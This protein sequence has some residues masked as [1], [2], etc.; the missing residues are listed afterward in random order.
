MKP[1]GEAVDLSRILTD[2]CALPDEMIEC[3]A[4]LARRSSSPI[5]VSGEPRHSLQLHGH[6]V[7]ED[8]EDAFLELAQAVLACVEGSDELELER[9]ES[10]RRE[11]ERGETVRFE[12]FFH[13]IPVYR[14]GVSLF[15]AAGS[16]L[17]ETV[18]V[19]L[20]R[21][22]PAEAEWG[23]AG[24]A[25]ATLREQWG[26]NDVEAPW[27]LR[28]GRKMWY[29]TSLVHGSVEGD[30]WQPAWIF[31]SGTD[32]ENP[33]DVVVSG[34]GQTVVDTIVVGDGMSL[35]PVPRYH[36][37][38]ETGVPDFVTWGQTGLL[39]PEAGTGDPAR[40][41]RALFDRYPTLF[42]T[43]DSRNQ[44][45]LMETSVSTGVPRT[46]HVVFQQMYGS[47]PVYGCQLR[48][49]LSPTLAIRSVSGTYLR[50]PQVALDVSVPEAQ[51]MSNLSVGYAVGDD[52]EAVPRSEMTSKGLVVF[53]AVLAPGGGP[54][55]HLAWWIA[56]PHWHYFVSAESGRV[57]Y[58]I[59][60]EENARLT[61]DAN[62][63]VSGE[64]L[65][66]RDGI[67]VT[68][69]GAPDADS[70]PTDM[71]VGLFEGFLL[72]LFGWRSWDNH[73]SDDIAIIDYPDHGNAHW[74]S[75]DNRARFDRNFTTSEVIG[76]EFTHGIV[77]TTAGLNYVGESGALNESFADVIGKL[78]F[79]GAPPNWK[80]FNN[81]GTQIRDLQNPDV[82]KYSKLNNFPLDHF[83]VHS[84][85]GISSR[86]AVLTCDGD[87][88]AGRSGIGRE[89]TT[90]LWWDVMTLRLHPW[91]TFLDFSHAVRE[92]VRD[93]A[94]MGTAGVAAPASGAAAG[95]PL[96]VFDMPAISQVDWA[97][98]QVELTPSLQSGWFTIPGTFLEKMTFFPGAFVPADEVVTTAEV[99]AIRRRDADKTQFLFGR[100]IVPGTGRFV[101]QSGTV[102]V[103]ITSH[104]VGSQSK[105]ITADITNTSGLNTEVSGNVYTQPIAPPPPSP[106]PPVTQ[107]TSPY[108]PHWF[109]NPLFLGRKYGDIIFEM[110]SMAATCTILDVWVEILEKTANGVLVPMGQARI[111]DPAAILRGTGVVLVDAHPGTS[112]LEAKVRSWHDFGQIVRYRIVYEISGGCMPPPFMFRGVDPA[113][114]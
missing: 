66:V 22:E 12:V 19:V 55:N 4:K 84:N 91:A 65:D 44:L 21:E 11:G 5:V 26:L 64:V 27:L 1:A 32:V 77:Q 81:D 15:V 46:K 79:P 80:S 93:L 53:P 33:F 73:G 110:V 89:L 109:D 45:S 36:I 16:G 62:Q 90:R 28:R 114:F 8:G 75:E 23:D 58:R 7:V 43:G 70:V 86:C 60:A 37:R 50:D 71:T 85:S 108:I 13:G 92:T 41:A 101:D 17:I 99:L 48:V 95:G 105:Q 14:G 98:D 10:D 49:H 39:L 52:R 9:R 112:L 102:I 94:S 111:G 96:P 18:S 29:S 38:P 67:V 88:A 113:T 24:V 78:A 61:Y 34:D 2:H 74:S 25:E 76:H 42:G 63:M 87:P 40:T 106:P 59:T 31:S 107:F 3:L 6:F 68:P 97:L 54:I 103:M 83:G 30:A 72:G 56:T 20:P 35:A 69:G 47:V 57:V 104:G 82:P 51:A 100:A